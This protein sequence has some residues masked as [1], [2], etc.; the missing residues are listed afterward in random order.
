VVLTGAGAALS[1]TP[2]MVAYG[3]TKTATH[4]LTKSMAQDPALAGVTSLAILP[5]TIDTAPN[6]AAMPHADFSDW[7][8]VG[9]EGASLLVALA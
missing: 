4:F 8:K 2:D 3:V 9:G 7:T 6:R 1:P 5:T